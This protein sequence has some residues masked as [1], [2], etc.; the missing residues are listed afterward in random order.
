M[1]FNV[2]NARYSSR[3]VQRVLLKNQDNPRISS[4]CLSMISFL[5]PFFFSF[6]FFFPNTDVKLHLGMPASFRFV[7]RQLDRRQDLSI[8]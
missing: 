2:S 3:S 5:P 6:S 1:A 4:H 7:D 8:A